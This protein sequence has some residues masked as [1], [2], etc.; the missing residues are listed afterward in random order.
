MAQVWGESKVYTTLLQ[1]ILDHQTE[2]GL[3]RVLEEIPTVIRDAINL[4]RRLGYRYL[5]VDSLCILQDS[6]RSWNLNA[7]A[8]DLIYGHASLTICAADGKDSSTPLEAMHPNRRTQHMED[9]GPNVRLMVTHLAET[10]IKT[11]K[12][13]SRAW[14]FQE[15]L[16]SRRCLIFTEKR[17]FFMCPSTMVSEDIV[18]STDGTGWSL[19]FIQAP[20]QLLREL[21]HR[22]IWVYIRCVAMY[23]SRGL[24]KPK[25]VLAAFNGISNRIRNHVKAPFVFGLPTSH[26]D[27]ALLW[28]PCGR[29]KRREPPPDDRDAFDGLE[30]PSWSWYVGLDYFKSSCNVNG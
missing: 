19:D 1:N 4:T 7:K 11:S 26:F 18:P 12:W 8:M 13:N 21:N 23:S 3:E 17:V 28:E 24:S 22:A 6:E 14:T 10:G 5:W 30:F 2:G 16:L 29:V 20:S 25:D 27:L 9:C 15:R